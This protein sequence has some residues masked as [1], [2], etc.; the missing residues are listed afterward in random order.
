[1][2]RQLNIPLV[3]MGFP[4]H[5]RVGGS[6]IL[7]IGYKGAQNL[8]DTLINTLLHSRQ[9]ASSVGYSYM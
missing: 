9:E 6:R 5:D 2:T 3:R 7:H 4:I 8:F 1:M